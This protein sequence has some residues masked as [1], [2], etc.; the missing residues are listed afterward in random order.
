M[1]E[2]GSGTAAAGAP[3]GPT[4]SSTEADVTEDRL[5]NG[6]VRLKQPTTGFRTGIDAVFLAAA[7]PARPG[8]KV[9]DVGSGTG[10]ASL[11]LA[12]RLAE[13]AVAGI[14]ADRALVRLA[15]ANAEANGM[16]G[17]AEFFLGDLIHPPIRFAAASFDHV[18]AN[19]P[20]RPAGSGRV[21]A[22]AGRARATIED[23]AKLDHWLRFCM[24]MARPQATITLIYAADRL[25]ELLT[26]V[27]GR[28]GG[29]VVYPLWPG[30]GGKPAKR[31]LVC[32]RRSSQAPLALMPG[33]VLHRPDGS[34][35]PQ[36][37][38]VLRGAEALS[39]TGDAS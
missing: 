17:R 12:A 18:M 39:L 31:V 5:L 30:V 10:A 1:S 38:A 33:L 20:Y 23:K 27:S 2:F 3:R 14:D 15:N 6:R 25:D 8:D 28:L 9:L 16:T 11:C 37:D 26:A 32:G 35:T 7:V 34:Y 29:L 36:A 13:V 19:P 22:N 4:E 21:P 24:I